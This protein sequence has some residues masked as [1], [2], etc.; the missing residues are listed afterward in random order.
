MGDFPFDCPD[1]A[2][3]IVSVLL[4]G[5]L[6]GRSCDE[7]AAALIF[8]SITLYIFIIMSQLYS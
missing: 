7:G 8:K 2:Q 6:R 3:E 1:C 5:A 4:Q